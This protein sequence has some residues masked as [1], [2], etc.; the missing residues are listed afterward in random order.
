MQDENNPTI[1]LS[2]DINAAR[3]LHKSVSFHLEKW[4]GAP[5]PREQEQ[6]VK[7]KNLF[8]AMLLEFTYEGPD[9]NR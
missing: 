5:D 1:D 7:L 6:L 4:A 8:S 2:I 9:G 3:L